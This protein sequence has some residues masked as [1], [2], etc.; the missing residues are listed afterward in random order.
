MLSVVEAS[1]FNG[2]DP[3]I[4]LRVTLGAFLRWLLINFILFIA[5]CGPAY[6]QHGHATDP[7]GAKP[8]ILINGSSCEIGHMFQS[9]TSRTCDSVT[10]LSGDSVSFC[11]GVN[12]DLSSDTAYYLKW[13]FN[14]SNFTSPVYDPYGTSLPLCYFPRWDV[15]GNYT[16]DV[17]Y[18]NGLTAYPYCDC[19]SFGPSHWI[20]SVKVLPAVSGISALSSG[21]PARV[22]PNPSNGVFTIQ[23]TGSGIIEVYDMLGEKIFV[24]SRPSKGGDGGEV[25]DLSSQPAGPYFYRIFS[26]GRTIA[27]GSLCKQ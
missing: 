1:L 20:I 4:P 12:I 11:T 26:E 24:S 25:I 23:R 14:G 7:L 2:D 18:N 27:S 22:F 6:S 21:Q 15:P 10:V 9:C 16:V 5:C 13:N 17:F 19:Y 8:E 3:A